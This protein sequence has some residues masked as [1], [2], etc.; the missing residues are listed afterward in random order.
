MRAYLEK[1]D[2][3]ALLNTVYSCEEKVSLLKEI[4]KAPSTLKNSPVE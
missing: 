4:V 1:V 2:V 3:P